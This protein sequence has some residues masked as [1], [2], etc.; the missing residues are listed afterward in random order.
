MKHEELVENMDPKRGRKD[1][2][3]QPGSKWIF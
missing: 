3:V 2:L 1:A